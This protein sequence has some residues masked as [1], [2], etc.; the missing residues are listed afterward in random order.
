MRKFSFV[1]LLLANAFIIYGKLIFFVEEPEV[2]NYYL[3]LV[4]VF[5]ILWMFKRNYQLKALFLWLHN[6][7]HGLVLISLPIGLVFA[8]IASLTLTIQVLF[9][10]Y[11]PSG[12]LI[13][14]NLAYLRKSKKV[15]TS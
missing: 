3:L 9:L 6:L 11:L 5:F 2:P 8:L 7:L 1:L 13:W 10:F 4:L 14:A 12:L 15:L